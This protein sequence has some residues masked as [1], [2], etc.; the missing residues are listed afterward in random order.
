MKKKFACITIL[1]AFFISMNCVNTF[2]EIKSNNSTLVTKSIPFKSISDIVNTGKQFVAVTNDGIL[3]SDNENEWV[4]RG[5]G[6]YS[7]L[8]SIAWNGKIFVTVGLMGTLLT[9][10]DGKQWMNRKIETGESLYKV[11][12]NGKIFI[13]VGYNG[14][15]LTS[16]DGIKWTTRKTGFKGSISDIIWVNNT[17]IAVGEFGTIL[18][19]SNS[20]KWTKIESNTFNYISNVVWNGNEYV[21]SISPHS[22]MTSIDL[23]SFTFSEITDED[24]ENPKLIYNNDKYVSLGNNGKI[25]ISSN[26][27][28]WSTIIPEPNIGVNNIIWDGSYFYLVGYNNVILKSNDLEN[29][30]S[31]INEDTK[32][33]S[34]T[35]GN[36][37]LNIG[38]YK[39]EIEGKPIISNGLLLAPVDTLIKY[40][41]GEVSTSTSS[42]TK[43][44]N[45]KKISVTTKIS[46]Q[47][48]LNSKNLF[49]EAGNR[50]AKVNTVKKDMRVAPQIINNKVYAPIK[51]ILDNLGKTSKWD[52]QNKTL[53]LNIEQ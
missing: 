39:I 20:I 16:P 34:I 47:I 7:S 28:E 14:I 15:I 25:Y 23:V 17:Y 40:L 10:N 26:L 3:T 38:N 18:K 52:L 4:I 49:I 19:S 21:F 36:S 5:L 9:S 46:L 43:Y 2:A 41:G 37:N 51:F 27:K 1:V 35:M 22:I 32:K 29:W 53:D 33:I 45:G 24:I 12:W 31:L 42:E 44:A 30:Q 11:L 6:K 50:Y 48:R 8:T 13:T